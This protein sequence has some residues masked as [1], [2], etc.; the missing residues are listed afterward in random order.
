MNTEIISFHLL[1]LFL[2]RL[3]L[4]SVSV[5]KIRAIWDSLKIIVPE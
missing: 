4:G 1:S 5:K 3:I 2:G